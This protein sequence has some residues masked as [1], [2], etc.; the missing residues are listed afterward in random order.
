ML[1]FITISEYNQSNSESNLMTRLSL[2]SVVLII[3]K[4]LKTIDKQSLEFMSF[5]SGDL[6]MLKVIPNN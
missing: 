5:F 4:K 1:C 2:T 6:I 3:C